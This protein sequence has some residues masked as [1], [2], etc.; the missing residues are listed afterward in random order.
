M[1]SSIRDLLK[2]LDKDQ[3]KKIFILQIL[4]IIMAFFELAG[5]LAIMPFMSLATDITVLEGNGIFAKIFVLLGFENPYSF[6]IFAAFASLF[7]ISISAI[8]SV[9]TMWRLILF[10]MELGASLSTRLY[11]YY[12]HQP[13]LFHVNTNSNQ[14]INKT[15]DECQRITTG[16]I[17]PLF[18]MV[19]KSGIAI[20]ITVAIF[21]YNPLVAIC[22]LMIFSSAYFILFLT[23]RNKLNSNGVK[24]SKFQG[25][26]YKLMGEGYGGIK[27]TLLMG[28]QDSFSNQFFYSTFKW[29]NLNASNNALGL[30]PRYIM[31]LIAFGGVIILIL[32]LLN[33]NNGNFASI[34][35][36][37]ALYA[38]AGFKLMPSF[39]QIYASMSSIKSN[40]P[41]FENLK[42]D[43]ISSS[44]F[45]NKDNKEYFKTFNPKKFIEFKDVNFRYPNMTKDVLKRINIKIPVN[46]TIGF[47]GSSGSGKSTLIDLFLGLMSPSSGDLIIDSKKLIQS[48]LHEW[49]K[50]LGFVP[51]NIFL[52]DSTI[53]ENIAF[54]IAK[55]EISNDQINRS[56]KMSHLESFVNSLPK[57]METNVGERGVQLSGGQRQRV[58]IARAL[59]NNADVLV[60]DEATS[61]LDGIT[62]KHIM[63]AVHD[64]SGT[65]TIIIIAHRLTTVKKCDLI[66]LLENGE[67][68]DTGNYE[69]LSKNN[70]L[71][72]SMVENSN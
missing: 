59:Y 60:L 17:Q 29:A 18:Y 69:F 9:F 46:K 23:V 24:I 4:V 48:N 70:K 57:G 33:S 54:G 39:Q 28:R 21:L 5:V 49:Q 42:N 38:L 43:L 22:A 52:A 44:E 66:Y 34:V 55:D 53:R 64:F 68:I 71:F 19:A 8:I 58:G 3:L 7:L 25:S 16:I 14:L 31:E 30:I 2:L 37:L 15:H 50:C 63:Q 11:K 26:R 61:S 47:V 56:I 36:S 41:A 65:K 6:L 51:Q 35:P 45:L 12:M 13:W 1:I 20:L 40:I 72:A 32:F 62:E 67:I 10:G 27:D